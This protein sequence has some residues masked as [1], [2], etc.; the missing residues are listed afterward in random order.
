MRTLWVRESEKTPIVFRVRARLSSSAEW[1]AGPVLSLRAYPEARSERSTVAEQ[2]QISYPATRVRSEVIVGDCRTVL[3]SLDADSVQTC[4]TSPP[5]LGI[6]DYGADGQI[7]LES[8]VQERVTSSRK[9]HFR[10]DSM[11]TC[12][13]RTV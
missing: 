1:A 6:R 11:N 4:I 2:L 10:D 12:E 13:I 8:T 5:Y 3:R 9:G 7:G